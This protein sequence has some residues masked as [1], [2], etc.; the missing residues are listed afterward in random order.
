MIILE[1]Q[2]RQN[3]RLTGHKTTRKNSISHANIPPP[4]RPQKEKKKDVFFVLQKLTGRRL[5]RAWHAMHHFV[6]SISVNTVGIV[7]K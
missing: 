2:I 3:R 7:R 4:P 1:R 5:M 6:Q